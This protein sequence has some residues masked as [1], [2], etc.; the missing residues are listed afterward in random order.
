M[1]DW[2]LLPLSKVGSPHNDSKR[3]SSEIMPIDG[4]EFLV[5][6]VESFVSLV[7]RQILQLVPSSIV[8]FCQMAPDPSAERT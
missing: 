5:V 6:S 3:Q 8:H 7:T 1:P 2:I 4:D